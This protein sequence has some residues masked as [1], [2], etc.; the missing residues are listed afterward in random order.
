MNEVITKSEYNPLEASLLKELQEKLKEYDKV[1]LPVFYL[2]DDGSKTVLGYSI[3]N[4][5]KNEAELH[6]GGNVLRSPLCSGVSMGYEDIRR[7]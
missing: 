4:Y 6:L 3:I 2:N 7:S 1:Q 5:S